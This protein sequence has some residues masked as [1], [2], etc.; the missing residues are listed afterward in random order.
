MDDLQI[1]AKSSSSSPRSTD[2]APVRPAEAVER[3]ER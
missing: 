2:A 1:H 3:Y